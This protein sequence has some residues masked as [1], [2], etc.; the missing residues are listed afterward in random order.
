MYDVVDIRG[1]CTAVPVWMTE[2]RWSN[3]KLSS[4]PVVVLKALREVQSLLK[5]LK[6]TSNE[7]DALSLEGVSYANSETESPPMEASSK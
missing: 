5:S 6:N 1:G 4:R 3:L 2:P 7:S